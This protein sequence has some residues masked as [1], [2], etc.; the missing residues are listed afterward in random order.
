MQV[1]P[2]A[3]PAE[4]VKAFKAFIDKYSKFVICSHENPDADAYGSACGLGVALRAYGKEVLFINTSPIL[5]RLSF[6]PAVSETVRDI[7]PGFEFEASIVCDCGAFSRVGENIFAQISGKPVLNIDHH[8]SNDNFGSENV[9]ATKASSTSEII[10][11]LLTEAAI[12]IPAQSAT[13]LYAGILADS[14]SF[15]YSCVRPYTFEAASLCVA[16]GAVSSKISEKLFSTNSLA[17]VKLHAKAILEMTLHIS[18][19]VALIVTSA[20]MIESCGATVADSD[21]LA[22]QGRDIQGVEVSVL[23]KEDKLFTS[24]S[25]KPKAIW[26]VS[27]RAKSDKY[28]V[29]ALAQKFGGGGHKA[30]AAF[31]SS[32]SRQEI[33]SALLAELEQIFA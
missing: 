27:M 4:S 8:I 11:A 32:K 28:D 1:S 29:S 14:G 5:E 16:K 9:V 26:R 22:E 19:K 2:H 7:P 3:I 33:I 24:D 13:A 21:G 30:A 23:M 18:S 15:R 17:Y 20:D 25:D 6:I 10:C 31:R 12:D